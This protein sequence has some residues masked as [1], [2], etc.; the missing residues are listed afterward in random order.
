[1]LVVEYIA[2]GRTVVRLHK[3][4]HPGRISRAWLPPPQNNVSGGDAFAL[5]SAFLPKFPTKRNKRNK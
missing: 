1:M 5:Q 2:N 3:D 4:W